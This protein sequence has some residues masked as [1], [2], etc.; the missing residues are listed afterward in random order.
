MVQASLERRGGDRSALVL[1]LEDP[2]ARDL[3]ASM[4]AD[5]AAVTAGAGDDIEAVSAWMGR[6][7]KWRR[8]LQG[9]GGGLT[10]QR[11]RGLF[12]ELLLIRDTLIPSVGFDEALRAWGGPDGEPRDFQL[13]GLAI[14][15]KT[16][17]A[18]EPQVVP[19]NGERQLDDSG[20]TSLT[21]VHYSFDIVRDAGE[22][23]SDLV[24][25]LRA[26]AEGSSEAGLLEDRLLQSGY[27]DDHVNLYRRIGYILRR[28]S[29][30]RVGAGFPRI[31]E[32][33]LPDGVGAVRY[34]LAIDVCR[35]FETSETE[36][37]ELLGASS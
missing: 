1:G 18:N 22:S 27:I 3:F 36:L 14:E 16:S 20:L 32:A 4:A 7:A 12:G 11:Q 19:V 5:V 28:R 30:F 6:F 2:G 29:L 35:E 31:V 10:P 17:A 34:R 26:L 15:V 8:M 24:M 25:K 21:L 13:H 37:T 9:G 33:D 23:L